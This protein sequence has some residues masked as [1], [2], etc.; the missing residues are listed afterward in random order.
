MSIHT[1]NTLER[2]GR[3]ESFHT[4]SPASTGLPTLSVRCL[5]AQ[6]EGHEASVSQPACRY[7]VHMSHIYIYSPLSGGSKCCH[8]CW[9]FPYQLLLRELPAVAISDFP[10]FPFHLGIP[11]PKA[12]PFS[13][14]WYVL[15]SQI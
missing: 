1:L 3:V 11:Q 4:M 2:P 15:V 10:G 5:L 14:I 9:G 13:V 8:L 6:K 12:V 7:V